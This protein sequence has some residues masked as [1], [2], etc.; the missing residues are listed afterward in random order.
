MKKEDLI[1]TIFILIGIMPLLTFFFFSRI[2][3]TA[4]FSN[5]SFIIMGI[6][7]LF[8]SRFWVFAEL[9][10]GLIPELLWTADYFWKSV[11][12][13]YLI[14]VTEYMFTPTGGF[15]WFHFYSLQHILFVP[16]AL[17]ALW[18]LGGPVK[19]AWQGSVMHGAGLWILGWMLDPELNINCV[20]EACAWNVPHYQ[21]MWPIAAIIALITLYQV[22]F[23]FWPKKENK[24]KN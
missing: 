24:R 10:I 23:N 21:I 2:E 17:Y 11:T 7:V 5:H 4:W 3:Y 20:R 12:G 15:D 13:N 19:N 14:G 1:G 9:L 6:A 18:V 8:R 16:A 22:L